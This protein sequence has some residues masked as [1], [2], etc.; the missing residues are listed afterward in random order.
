MDAEKFSEYF[1]GAPVFFGKRVSIRHHTTVLFT[2]FST[3]TSISGGYSLYSSTR[4]KLSPCFHHNHFP[5]PY[6]PAERRHPSFLH[7]KSEFPR[8]IYSLTCSSSR[9]KMKSKQLKRTCRK[10][11]VRSATRLQSLLSVLFTQISRLTCRQRY[12][13]LHLQVLVRSSWPLILQR[14]VSRS[15]VWCL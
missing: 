12:S 14:R 5:D 3:W 8:S 7:R 6:N 13:S 9:A 11:R 2:F 15:M 10:P 4:S 1:D